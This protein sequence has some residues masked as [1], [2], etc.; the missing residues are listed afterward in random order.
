[1]AKTKMA[2]T[3]NSSQSSSQATKTKRSGASKSKTISAT[4]GFVGTGRETLTKT[5]KFGKV[6]S[7][8]GKKLDYGKAMGKIQK[9]AGKYIKSETKK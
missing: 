7:E 5:D 6:L 9:S 8:K 2:F 1:M 4:R 3:H